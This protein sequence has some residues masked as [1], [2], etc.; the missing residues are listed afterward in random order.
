MEVT[1]KLGKVEG[2]HCSAENELLKNSSDNDS[3]LFKTASRLMR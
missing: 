1:G 3:E 2:L